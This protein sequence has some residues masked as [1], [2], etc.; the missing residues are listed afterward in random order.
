MRLL[1]FVRRCKK[2]E[3]DERHDRLHAADNDRTFCGKELDSMWFIE[4]SHGLKP[5]DVTCK[6]CLKAMKAFAE[7][8]KQSESTAFV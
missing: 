8:E 7:K 2:A 5:E 4:S 6:E 3:G 1:N